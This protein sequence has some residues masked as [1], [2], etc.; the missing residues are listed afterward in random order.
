MSTIITPREAY[1]REKT[2]FTLLLK[3]KSLKEIATVMNIGIGSVSMVAMKIYKAFGVKS[4]K[5][6]INKFVQ[7]SNNEQHKT[8]GASSQNSN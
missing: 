7:R 4:K 5:E 6:L 3:G 1:Q 2:V 8:N